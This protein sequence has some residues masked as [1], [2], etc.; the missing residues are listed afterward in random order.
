MTDTM[1]D[2]HLQLID[3]CEKR[4]S[5]L[6]DWERGF[7]DSIARRIQNGGM[8]TVKQEETLNAIWER[9]TKNG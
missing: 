6:S 3:D 5:H 4:E 1:R 9:A 2:E 8:L 7:V